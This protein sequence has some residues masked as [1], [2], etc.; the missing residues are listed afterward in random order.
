M[1]QSCVPEELSRTMRERGF[2]IGFCLDGKTVFADS[3][4]ITAD[5]ERK[6]YEQ[7]YYKI[8]K[9]RDEYVFYDPQDFRVMSTG[10]RYVGESTAPQQPMN[11]VDY[12]AMF[13]NLSNTNLDLSSWYMP[14]AKSVKGMIVSSRELRVLNLSGWYLSSFCDASRMLVDVPRLRKLILDRSKLECISA[15]TE[16]FANA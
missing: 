5:S 4:N 15:I 9:Y 6:L 16:L 10:L 2:D 7:L 3:K 14:D 8:G 13:S 11:V 1:I 12:R